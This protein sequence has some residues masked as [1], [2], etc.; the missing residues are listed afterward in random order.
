[1]ALGKQRGIALRDIPALELPA[2]LET[3]DLAGLDFE[4]AVERRTVTG[5]TARGAV[6]VQLQ[7]VK[8]LLEVE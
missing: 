7:R 1:M 6:R 5:G 2:P 3:R 4:K 8:A